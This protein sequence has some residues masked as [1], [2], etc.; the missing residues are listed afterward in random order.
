M[1]FDL[2]KLLFKQVN[3]FIGEY[4]FSIKVLLLFEYT[5]LPFFL[6]KA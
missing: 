4:L 6:N 2:F 5:F 1:P 3:T